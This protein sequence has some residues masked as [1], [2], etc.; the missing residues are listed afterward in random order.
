MIKINYA[1]FAIPAFFI[2]LLLEYLFGFGYYPSLAFITQATKDIQT[3]I[4]EIYLPLN[5]LTINRLS[6][7]FFYNC[8][9]LSTHNY[10]CI[11]LFFN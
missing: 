2:V 1:A 10:G 8:T 4:L 9:K 6:D 11:L 7:I 5:S 3:R